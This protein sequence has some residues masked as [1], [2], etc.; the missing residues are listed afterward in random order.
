MKCPNCG[1]DELHLN[2]ITEAKKALPEASKM[3]DLADFYKVMG[4]ETRLKLLMSLDNG[5]L[6]VSDL[7]CILN[8]TLSAI[9]HQLKI[10]RVA[11]LVK[12][13]KVGKV[14]YYALDDD[15]VKKNIRYGLRTYLRKRRIVSFF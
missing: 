5:P 6:C 10:L 9:S 12:S 15:H 3:T 11:K 14:V 13:T 8:M 1:G 7:S 4:D 2:R